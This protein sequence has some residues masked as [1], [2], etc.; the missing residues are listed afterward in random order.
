MP[1]IILWWCA[2]QPTYLVVGGKGTTKSQPGVAVGRRKERSHNAL[3]P[4][5][6]P[7]VPQY[8]CVVQYY[9]AYILI[10]DTLRKCCTQYSTLR[11]VGTFLRVW[12]GKCLKILG[13]KMK[14]Q[15]K[16]RDFEVFRL[17]KVKPNILKLSSAKD[18]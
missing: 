17:H 13:A 18:G 2:K 9:C 3:Y 16:G 12:G 4:T 7:T 1:G 14:W 10:W 15:E 11:T 6:P 8:V 5:L